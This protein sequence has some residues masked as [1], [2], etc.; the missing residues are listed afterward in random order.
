MYTLFILNDAPYG[1]ERCYNAL[2]LATA[3]HK[4]KND[5]SITVFLLADAVA[6]AKKGQ[7]VA[8]GFYNVEKMLARLVAA[9]VQVL[10][11]GTCMEARGITDTDIV[12]GA[13]RST[14]A[15]LGALTNEA[16][17]VIVF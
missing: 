14:M 10:L 17:K 7:K 11:C 1:N 2:R 9:E 3:L 12:E 16:D 15:E 4:T 6:A 5:A 8:E 13:R